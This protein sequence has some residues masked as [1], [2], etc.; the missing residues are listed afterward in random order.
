MK[1]NILSLPDD[2]IGKIFKEL[3][4]PFENDTRTM[5]EHH[6]EILISPIDV[7]KVFRRYELDDYAV[8]FYMFFGGLYIGCAQNVGDIIPHVKE[9][10]A[11]FRLSDELNIDVSDINP[12]EA[13]DYF[14]NKSKNK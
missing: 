9:L 4:A 3:Y 6:R 10:V 8:Q 13:L 2:L 7:V 12:K 11:A 1:E 14:K 5:F